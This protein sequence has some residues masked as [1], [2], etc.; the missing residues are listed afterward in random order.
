MKTY[1][2]DL[3]QRVVAAVERGVRREQVVETFGVSL[4]TIKRYLRRKRVG[5]GLTPKPRRGRTPKITGERHAELE[6]QLRAHD[7]ATLAEH[8]RMWQRSHGTPL[9]I[10]AMHRAIKRLGWTRKKGRWAPPSGMRRPGPSG[11]S[12]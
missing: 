8:A 3:R 10:W 1:S 2:V 9:S 5:A 6:A 4:S 11:E 7:T 12:G